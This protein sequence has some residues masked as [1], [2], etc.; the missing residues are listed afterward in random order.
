VVKS[1]VSYADETIITTLECKNQETISTHYKMLGKLTL[2][3][4]KEIYQQFVTT[5]EVPNDGS[6]A[7]I[8]DI[9]L[10]DFS[11]NKIIETICHGKKIIG[12]NLAE[13]IRFDDANDKVFLHCIYSALSPQYRNAGFM[14]HLIFRAA[15]SLQLLYDKKIGVFYSAIHINSYRLVEAI[16]EKHFPKHQAINNSDSM[17]VRKILDAIYQC[18]YVYFHHL[19]TC[20]TLDQLRVKG[21]RQSKKPSLNEKYYHKEILGLEEGG[22]EERET[23]GAPILF[24]VNRKNYENMLQNAASI[25]IRFDVNTLIFATFMQTCLIDMI[26]LQSRASVNELIRRSNTL[27]GTRLRNADETTPASQSRAKL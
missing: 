1:D 14:L 17:L 26:S 7:I 21:P 16:E 22:A 20:Y 10:N 12:F 23:R 27:F 9:F 24:Y 3:E 19:V 8:R 15:Y 13:I 5:F 25:G 11:G 18:D 4:R 6:Q 2:D